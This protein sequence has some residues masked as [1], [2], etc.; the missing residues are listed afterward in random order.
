MANKAFLA[1]GLL[2]LPLAAWAGP[3]EDY[4]ALVTAAKDGDPGVDYTV[5][6]QSYT[7][8]PDY[9]P[10]GRKTDGLMHDAQAAYIAGDCKTALAKF[11]MALAF[12]FTLSDA[13]ALSADCLEK[14]GDKNGMAREEAIA[15]GLFNSIGSTGTGRTPKTALWVVTRHEEIVVFALA[16]LDGKGQTTLS[17]D[18]GPVDKFTVTD[19]KTGKTGTMYFNVSA[20]AASGAAAA[21][22]APKQ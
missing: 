22:P 12:N 20:M 2:L 15:Q 3:A 17:T 14:A 5:M 1:L 6:R 8:T 7:R 10:F 16:G 11:K 4:A 19:V 9:D 18:Q 21:A 13:H